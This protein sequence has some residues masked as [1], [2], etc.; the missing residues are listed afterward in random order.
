LT[1]TGDISG[2]FDPVGQPDASDFPQ[3]RI[4]L[5]G[6]GS[7]DTGANST[8]LGATLQRRTR[9]L[10]A[11]RFPPVTHKLVKRWHEFPRGTA[12]PGYVLFPAMTPKSDATKTARAYTEVPVQVLKNF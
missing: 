3:R 10:P 8:L 11:W 9:G 5:L 4:G 12:I 6:S 1:Y 2:H 7:I